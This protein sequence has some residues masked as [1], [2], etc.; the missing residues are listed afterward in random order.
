MLV[1]GS[2]GSPGVVELKTLVAEVG[3]AVSA[4]LGGLQGLRRFT[5]AAHDGDAAKTHCVPV[6]EGE[7]QVRAGTRQSKREKQHFRL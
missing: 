6:P 5:E 3:L 4:A 7:D 2:R 1:L